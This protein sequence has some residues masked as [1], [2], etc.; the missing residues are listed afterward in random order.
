MSRKREHYII[1]G[2]NVIN[3][4][5]ELVRLRKDLSAARDQLVHQ[6]AEYGAYEKLDVTIVFDAMFTDDEE[7]HEKVNDHMELIYTGEGET[8]DS[9]IERLA[10]DSVRHG[11]EVHVVTS[12]GAEQAVVLGV[13]AFRVSSSEFRRFVQRIKKQLKKEYLGKAAL[14]ISRL[15]VAD[16]LD[17]DTVRKLDALRKSQHW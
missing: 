14:P 3:S 1:D 8:A 9:R 10:Y 6:L 17:R 4:W 12:D 16:R 5:P 2:Y 11:R 15:E 13:G 7:H